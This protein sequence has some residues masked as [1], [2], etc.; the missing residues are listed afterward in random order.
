MLLAKKVTKTTAKT[1]AKSAATLKTSIEFTLQPLMEEGKM[2]DQLAQIAQG[3]LELDKTL[4]EKA[5]KDSTELAKNFEKMESELEKIVKKVQGFQEYVVL[6]EKSVQEK[7]TSRMD[8]LKEAKKDVKIQDDYKRQADRVIGEIRVVLDNA[9]K[10]LCQLA[11]SAEAV[12]K[13]V[14]LI[15]PKFALFSLPENIAQSEKHAK[16]LK[17]RLEALCQTSTEINSLSLSASGIDKDKILSSLPQLQANVKSCNQMIDQTLLNL[18]PLMLSSIG[19]VVANM[20]PQTATSN[21]PGT[22]SMVSVS[23][24]MNANA[25]NANQF[26]HTGNGSATAATAVVTAAAAAPNVTVI[27]ANGNDDAKNDSTFKKATASL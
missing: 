14:N 9:K 25:A 20:N 11:E 21:L 19:I 24:A 22:A 12:L 10:K 5:K 16:K 13:Q 27:T 23:N 6:A 7:L 4:I 2:K 26:H 17:E 1:L 8:N 15:K 3:F 18:K